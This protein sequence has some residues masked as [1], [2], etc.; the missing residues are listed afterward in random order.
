M[1]DLAFRFAAPELR[2]LCVYRAFQ[3]APQHDTGRGHFGRR[4]I[5]AVNGGDFSGER[6]RGVVLPG[7]GDWALVDD[8]RDV[9]RLDARVVWKTDD[10]AL[11][12]IAYTGVFRPYSEG[13]KQFVRGGT[14]TEGDTRA[15]YF[16]T[17]PVFE[18]GH[19]NYLW[20][21]DIVCLGLGLVTPEGVTY[22]IYEVA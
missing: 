19:S 3:E 1:A 9:L 16:R 2:P 14:L 6:L 21:N 5:A 15:L 12:H 11:I 20:L 18:T 10:G 13:P 8:A 4:K 7:G 17:R 22:E